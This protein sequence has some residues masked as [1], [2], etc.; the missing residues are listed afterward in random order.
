MKYSIGSSA[1]ETNRTM[2]GGAFFA[3]MLT[4]M[5]AFVSMM[6]LMTTKTE[7][8]KIIHE[9]VILKNL[10]SKSQIFYNYL[11]SKAMYKKP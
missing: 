11:K 8:M 5:S 1:S 4:R 7:T 2:D 9:K 3:R 6:I 10:L